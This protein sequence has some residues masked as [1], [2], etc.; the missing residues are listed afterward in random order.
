MIILIFTACIPIDDIQSRTVYIPKWYE[1]LLLSK[2]IYNY[3]KRLTIFFTVWV[4][5]LLLTE[6]T[7]VGER[8][9]VGMLK[10]VLFQKIFH[11]IFFL[12]RP[13]IVFFGAVAVGLH[14]ALFIVPTDYSNTF[15]YVR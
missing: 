9:G 1:W 8:T 10:L 13:L 6:L 14:L 2:N 4:S 5:G 11:L 3:E 7:T 15:L 12:F